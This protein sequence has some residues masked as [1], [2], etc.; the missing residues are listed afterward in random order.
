MLLKFT[1]TILAIAVCALA[2]AADQG[3]GAS[4]GSSGGGEAGQQAHSAKLQQ[5]PDQARQ[6]L[7]KEARKHE[8][9]ITDVD[10]KQRNGVSFYKADLKNPDR[11]WSVKILENGTIV[12]VEKGDQVKFEELP[13][14][15]RDCLL[16]EARDG[17]MITEIDKTR[18]DGQ[19]A[20]EAEIEKDG[21][22]HD[23]Y[24][25]AEGRKL[26]DA[27]GMGAGMD[28]ASRSIDRAAERAGKSVDRAA[29][30]AAG[31]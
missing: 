20:Y 6:Q 1:N 14:Q 19:M 5:V 25:S 7:I 27:T 26:P 29:D 9:Q 12:G 10:L 17:A 8:A 15:V 24:V 21:K 3:G 30:K 2:P 16:Q 31:R 28:D 11:S 13:Q 18:R 23:V 4:G 22:A